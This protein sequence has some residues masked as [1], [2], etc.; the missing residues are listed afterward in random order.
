VRP[1]GRYLYIS[2]NNTRGSYTPRFP[3]GDNE[4]IGT[5][6]VI[7]AGTG[8]IVKVIEVEESATGLGIRGG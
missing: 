7:D 6:T 3:L 4:R 5:V 1:D 8:E 2:S